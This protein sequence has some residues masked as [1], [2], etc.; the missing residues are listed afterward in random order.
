M[1]NRTNII[2]VFGA[3]LLLSTSAGAQDAVFDAPGFQ[4]HRDYFSQEPYENIDTLSG[5]LV[6]TF[7][8]LVLPGNAG[9]ELRFQRTY[10]S[11]PHAWTF[12][13]AG[14]P[15]S[16][17]NPDGP[18]PEVPPG[19]PDYFGM[20][21]LF[22]A[23][24]AE[25]RSTPLSAD[26]VMTDNFWRYNVRTHVAE[27]PNGNTCV[28]DSTGRLTQIRD[29]YGNTVDVVRD[30]DGHVRFLQT[31]GAGQ[32]REVSVTTNAGGSTTSISYSGHTWAFDYVGSDLMRVTPPVGPVWQYG[33]NDNHELTSVVNP[34][35]GTVTY[36]Y[37]TSQFHRDDAT[38]PDGRYIV[39]SRVV[40]AK[41]RTDRGAATGSTWSYEYDEPAGAVY[42]EWYRTQILRPDGSRVVYFHGPTTTAP[43]AQ[44]GVVSRTITS[45]AGSELEREDRVYADA[46]SPAQTSDAVM[47]QRRVR[48]GAVTYTTDFDFNLTDAVYYADYHQPWRIRESGQLSRVTTRTF[49]HF[50]TPYVVGL[51]LT[52][53]IAVATDYY[54]RSWTYEAGTGFRTSETAYGITTSFTHDAQGN[55][56]KTAKA[57]GKATTYTYSWGALAQTTTPEYIVTRAINPDGAVA[58]ESKAGRTTAYFYDD[59]SRPIRIQPP[60]YPTLSN[61]TTIEYDNVAGA[62]VTTRRGASVVT[63]TLDGFGR[64]VATANGV[65]IKRT[66]RYDAEGRKVYEGYPFTGTSDIGTTVTYDPL[67]RVVRRTNPDGSYNERTYGDGTVTIRDEKDRHTVQ[68]YEAFGDPDEGRLVG[69]TDADEKNWTY[70]YDGIGRLG[71]VTAPDGLER[72]WVYDARGLLLTE[73]HPESGTVTYNEYDAAGVLKRKTDANGTVFQYTYDG[74]DRVKTI[75]AATATAG[76]KLTTIDYEPGSDN[77]QLMAVGAVT[78]RFAYDA[79]GRLKTRQD[80]IDGRVYTTSVTYDGNDNATALK[81]PSGREVR[82]E[83]DAEGRISRVFDATGRNY[84]TSFDYHPSGAVKAYDA[85]NGTQFR[86]TLDD[87]RYW[88][89][90]ITSGPLDLTYGAYDLTGNVGSIADARPEFSQTF[91]YDALDRL[92][93]AAGAYG[94]LA[95]AYDVHGNRQ[96]FNGTSYTYD[97]GT[98]RLTSQDDRTFTYDNNGN[99][100]A[101][102]GNQ[103]FTY[104]PQNLVETATVN[105]AVS[106]YEYDADDWRV[107]KRGQGSTTIYLRGVGRELLTEWQN[108]GASTQAIR[109]YVYAGSRMLAVVAR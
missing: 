36:T 65:G 7:T 5:S 101:T 13:V 72:S 57:N 97:V 16:V 74:N 2:V 79:A 48:R 18:P 26:L 49:Q 23:D 84:A 14:V 24:G 31:L 94:S 83:L 80:A 40:T 39:Y 51:P 46:P 93:T 11:K 108:P 41:T 62:A 88:P 64:P 60:G 53:R 95:Y 103:V 71:K 17:S 10:N 42:P 6:L 37:D 59:L 99:L 32:V 3:A 90:T 30:V 28:F 50:Q 29:V 100:R 54:D 78:T 86:A 45:E 73:T 55:L 106:T 77:R 66:T 67:G 21:V 91:T 19:T 27:L 105:G 9:Q 81:Y 52:E 92:K 15:M 89:T 47:T 38:A 76:T 43:D 33:Y 34:H 56:A 12:G 61:A 35:G 107:V 1:T 70:L 102:S 82:Y 44:V 4:K 69:V 109:D 63:T 20:P 98:L 8:D 96:T 104:T 22:S 68:R 25:H 58:S 75:N 85:G 87:L